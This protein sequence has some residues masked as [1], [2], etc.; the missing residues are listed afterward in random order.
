MSNVIDFLQ[1]KK[2]FQKKQT[3]VEVKEVDR[4]ESSYKGS[5]GNPVGRTPFVF[6]NLPQTAVWADFDVDSL[7]PPYPPDFDPEPLVA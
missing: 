3:E 5:R 7:P 2:E 1:K 6:Q 4:P